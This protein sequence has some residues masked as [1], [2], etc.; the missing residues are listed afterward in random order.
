MERRELLRL[1]AL[2]T[3]A[4]TRAFAQT[5][6]GDAQNEWARE[7]A[8]NFRAVYSDPRQKAAF[9]LF[10]RNVFHLYPE[11]KFHKLIEDV[12]LAKASD[13]EVYLEVQSRLR[14]IKP[15]LAQ[16]RYALPALWKQKLEMT[17][18]TLELIGP[19]RAVDGYL[20]IGTTGRYVSRLKSSLAIKGDIVLVHTN[21]ASYAPDDIV[22]RGRI[23]K[24]GRFVPLDDYAPI[25]ASAVRDASLDLVT[26]FI[27]FH[28]SPADRLD[29]F[30]RSLHRVLRPGGRMIV[31][32]HDV[33]SGEMDRMAALAHDVFNMGLGADWA[34]N[35][36]EIRHFTGNAALVSYLRGLGFEND[37]RFLFQPGDPTRNALMSFRRV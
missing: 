6:A 32:D 2:F 26:N 33:D 20:E 21:G 13:K 11:Q 10:L 37:G 18:E 24:L 15:F 14:T 3:A 12:S 29:G 28:H 17:R 23:R 36:K 4:G 22:E 1:L 5:P 25:P 35:Q 34:V 8:S 9:L 16:F 31:R 27:G 30:V 7:R 19:R